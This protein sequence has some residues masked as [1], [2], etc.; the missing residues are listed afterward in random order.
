MAASRPKRSGNPAK[1]AQAASPPA[2]STRGRVNDRSRALLVRLSALPPLLIP[3]AILLLMLVGLTAP[4]YAALPALLV[5]AAFVIW[6]AYLSW[7]VLDTKGRLVRGI[8]VGAVLAALVGRI[9]G[10]L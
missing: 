6:L 5:I 8:M 1:R 9:G 3:G 4:L 2:S 10:W 7:P